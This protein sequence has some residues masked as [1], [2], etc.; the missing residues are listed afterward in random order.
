MNAVV[1]LTFTTQVSG[2]TLTESIEARGRDLDWTIRVYDLYGWHL[3][4]YKYLSL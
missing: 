4:G 1:L 2:K 3:T